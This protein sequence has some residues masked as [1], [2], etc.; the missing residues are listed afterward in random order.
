MNHN[1]ITRKYSITRRYRNDGRDVRVRGAL[2]Q[3]ASLRVTRNAK[4]N[5]PSLSQSSR[6]IARLVKCEAQKMSEGIKRKFPPYYY[7]VHVHPLGSP[8]RAKAAK[9]KESFERK[10]ASRAGWKEKNTVFFFYI[11]WHTAEINFRR[12]LSLLLLCLLFLELFSPPVINMHRFLL[13]RH[14]S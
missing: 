11:L 14:P 7:F 5:I 9:R 8:R 13:L 6:S 4:E 1:R 12:S 3:K 10:E 2:E